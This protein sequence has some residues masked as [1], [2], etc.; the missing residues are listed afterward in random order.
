MVKLILKGYIKNNVYKNV[1]R[2]LSKKTKA[3]FQKR[4]VKSTKILLKKKKTKST[5]MVVSDKEIF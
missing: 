4:L 3:G 2:L 5:N 1:N